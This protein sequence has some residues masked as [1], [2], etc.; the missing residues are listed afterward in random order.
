[1]SA[2]H[3]NKIVVDLNKCSYAELM[4]VCHSF[5]QTYKRHECPSQPT[6][7]GHEFETSAVRDISGETL[8][9]YAKRRKL[10]DTWTPELTLQLSNSHSLVFTGVKAQSLWAM[11]RAKQF[12]KQK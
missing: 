10:L 12:G 2:R 4:W 6:V 8:L 11:W 9:T 5:G 1:M 3:N 7:H